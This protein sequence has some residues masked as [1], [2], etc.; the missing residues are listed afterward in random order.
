MTQSFAIHHSRFYRR[1]EGGINTLSSRSIYNNLSEFIFFFAFAI[2]SPSP[3]SCI[4][5]DLFY[6]TLFCFILS[7]FCV[8]CIQFTFYENIY[9]LFVVYCECW[10]KYCILRKWELS[11]SL[12][13]TP[14][15]QLVQQSTSNQNPS[16]LRG[17]R[18]S[19]CFNW[20]II[21]WGK[22]GKK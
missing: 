17:N 11:I 3:F 13:L 14:F 20:T 10:K 16:K 6:F 9:A 5:H 21:I 7:L 4:I 19:L 2:F 1:R 15:A 12:N 18:C 22:F 8:I